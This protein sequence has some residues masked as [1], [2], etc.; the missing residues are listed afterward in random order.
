MGGILYV[1]YGTGTIWE[2]DT[3]CT[4]WE[5]DTDEYGN[6]ALY[7]EYGNGTLMNMGMDTVCGV[8]TLA[9]LI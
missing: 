3:V 1:E 8:L 5:W 4:I 2:W 7:I 9:K 6:G